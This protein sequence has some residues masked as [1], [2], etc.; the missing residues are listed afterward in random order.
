MFKLAEG[1]A[2]SCRVYCAE[3]GLYLA[4]VPLIERDDRG[5]Y[6][7]RAES[8]IEALLA[9]AYETPPDLARSVARLRTV[10]GHFQGGDLSL[11]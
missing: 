1:R 7:L 8:E 6:R 11:A 3:E 2:A 5:G 9:A 10:L 4:G